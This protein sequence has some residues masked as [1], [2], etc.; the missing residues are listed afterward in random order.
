MLG[1][2]SPREIEESPRHPRNSA[3]L[4][5]LS[6]EARAVR[7]DAS[8]AVALARRRRISLDEATFEVGSVVISEP[9]YRLIEPVAD[10]KPLGSPELKG[11]SEGDPG[12]RAA[13]VEKRG[14]GHG[15][16]GRMRLAPGQGAFH[17]ASRRLNGGVRLE[18]PSR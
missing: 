7:A 11:R 16:S 10:V 14:A 1:L 17:E 13:G 9:T 6:A 4:M 15:A 5:R 3:E 18:T 8:S 2:A 12:L